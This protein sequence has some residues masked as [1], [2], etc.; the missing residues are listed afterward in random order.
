MQDQYNYKRFT[1]LRDEWFQNFASHL[2]VGSPAPTGTLQNLETRTEID[3]VNLFQSSP[4]ILEFG[5]F[6]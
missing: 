1:T 4:T 2:P 5:S 3:L 6:T